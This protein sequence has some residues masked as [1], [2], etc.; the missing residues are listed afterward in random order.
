LKLPGLDVAFGQAG[1]ADRLGRMMLLQSAQ[2]SS[3]AQ[4][5]LD[6]PEL[7]SLTVRIQ[8]TDQAAAV[9]FVSP[10]AMLRDALE[11][12]S[13]R[14]QELFREQGRDLVDVSVSDQSAQSGGEERGVSG[15]TGPGSSLWAV[16]D[17]LMPETVV[18]KPG[19]LIDFYA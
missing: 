8:L 2:G 5:R 16:G 19:A 17:Q 15:G 4:I 18:K 11:Q 14:L 10:H 1:W 6:P 3:S 13:A 9:N 7:G 12:Q